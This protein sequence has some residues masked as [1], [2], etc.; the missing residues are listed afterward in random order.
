MNVL[1]R[2]LRSTALTHLVA[3][4]LALA[5][6]TGHAQETTASAS[7]APSLEEIVVTAQKREERLQ[8]VP[9]A[10]SAVSGEELAANRVTDLYTLAASVPWVKMTQDSAVSQQLNIRGVVSVKLN[11]ASAEPSVAPTES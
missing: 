6:G 3:W 2:K 5:T 8:D 11:D 9:V 10:I 1:D 4:P 7:T